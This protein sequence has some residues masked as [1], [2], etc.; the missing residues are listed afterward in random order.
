VED[1][2]CFEGGLPELDGDVE[3]LTGFGDGVGGSVVGGA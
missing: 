2:V 1:R 3:V